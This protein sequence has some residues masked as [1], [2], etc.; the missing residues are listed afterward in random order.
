V[1]TVTESDYTETELAGKSREEL[2]EIAGVLGLDPASYGSKKDE[3]AA[4]LAAQSE[5]DAA[6]EAQNGE[7]QQSGLVPAADASTQGEPTSFAG[8]DIAD[9][10]EAERPEAEHVLLTAEAWVTL[11]ET[12]GLPEWAVGNPASVVSAPVSKEVDNDG[13]VL[14]EYTAPDAI[15]TVRERSQGATFQVPL[16]SCIKV[17]PVGG[18]GQVVNFV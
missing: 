12:E 3:V 1:S 18:R 4:I 16:D 10:P 7:P 6:L 13:N 14:Y 15:I 9:V 17:S 2:D 8:V 11:G 5:V